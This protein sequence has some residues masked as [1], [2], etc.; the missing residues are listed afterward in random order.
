M[1]ACSLATPRTIRMP[2]RT[3]EAAIL[4]GRL[5]GAVPTR[6]IDIDRADFDA[7][8]AGI[9]YDL[10]RR[11]EAHRLCIK[12]RCAEDV[13]MVAFHPGGSVGD[14]GEAGGMAFGKP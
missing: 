10:G 12:Q 1:A 9:A 2:S 3:G 7:M 8:F 11:I 14:K 4:F 13:G 6:A 5:Q